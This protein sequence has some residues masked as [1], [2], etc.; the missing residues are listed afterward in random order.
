M[1]PKPFNIETTSTVNSA[2]VCISLKQATVNVIHTQAYSETTKGL[3]FLQQLSFSSSFYRSFRA[4][5]IV[6]QRYFVAEVVSCVA[7]FM[8]SDETNR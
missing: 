4:I 5:H 3:P 7:Y 1:K 6:S 2:F 8:L